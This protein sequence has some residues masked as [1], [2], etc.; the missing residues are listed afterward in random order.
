MTNAVLVLGML[1]QDLEAGLDARWKR[2]DAEYELTVTGK[3]RGLAEGA[4]VGLRF[5]ALTNR[6]DWESR[7]IETAPQE[8]GPG[9]VAIVSA[10]AFSHAERFAAPGEVEVRFLFDGLEGPVVRRFR[11]GSAGDVVGA[12]RMAARRIE[13]AV[14][15]IAGLVEAG[16]RFAE[17]ECPNGRSK[18]ELRRRLARAQ[19]AVRRAVESSGLPASAEVVRAIGAD[20]E[21]AILAILDER[22]LCRWISN[23]SG[24]SFSLG[25]AREYLDG[26]E[27]IA[28]RELRLTLLGELDSAR[29]G[30]Q[31]AVA[32]GDRR[33]WNRAAHAAGQAVETVR[34]AG[35]EEL[36]RL[37]VELEEF[38]PVAESAM[39]CESAMSGEYRERHE[40]LSEKSAALEQGLRGMN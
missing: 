35:D 40:A 39:Q 15:E 20:V 13:Q 9:R 12:A 28:A 18:L 7:R 8:D 22:P 1:A 33:L 4:T 14:T 29:V 2:A 5:H 38:L 34:R 27:A 24:K 36:G 26:A 37:A 32:S 6:A 31:A 19:D 3:P 16:E 11:V 23:L 21:A 17:I 10:G 25:E 30:V